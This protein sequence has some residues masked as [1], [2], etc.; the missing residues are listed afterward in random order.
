MPSWTRTPWPMSLAAGVMIVRRPTRMVR[1]S[2]MASRTSASHTKSTGLAGPTVPLARRARAP[3]PES[4]PGVGRARRRKYPRARAVRPAPSAGPAGGGVEAGRGGHH[5]PGEPLHVQ[6]VPRPDVVRRDVAAVAA[7][8]QRQRRVEPRRQ[9]NRP[10]RGGRVHHDAERR[11]LEAE[12]EDHRLVPRVDGHGVAHAAVAE[13]LLAPL[14]A[15][16]PVADDVEGEDRAELLDRERVVA[17]DARQGRDEHA[18]LGRHRQARLA[19]HLDGGPAHQRGVGQPLRGDERAADGVGL[20]RREEVARPAGRTPAGPRR[21]PARRPRRRSP[22]SRAARCRTSCPSRCR[23]R[24]SSDRRSA[25]CRPGRCPGPRR[26][27]ACP[28]C[29]R[30][31]PA[32]GRRSPG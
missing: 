28:C 24:P 12:L 6:E 9:A 16:P 3:G 27:R 13:D 26:R 32:P 22:T 31:A 25:R 11:L 5:F 2:L 8:A 15:L 19:R 10:V 7:A 4:D 21:R 14:A 17:A 23:G 1:P 18:R 20:L 30:R 29:R